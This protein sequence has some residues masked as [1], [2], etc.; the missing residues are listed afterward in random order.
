MMMVSSILPLL[1]HG[2]YFASINLQNAYFHVSIRE[3][4]WRFLSFKILHQT[5]QFTVL[6]F[7]LITAPRVFT[8]TIAVVAAHLRQQGVM[9]FPYLDW[10]IAACSLGNSRTTCN[11]FPSDSDSLGL[12]LNTGEIFFNSVK[13]DKGHRDPLQLYISNG[14][15]PGG[16]VPGPAKRNYF[17]QIPPKSKHPIHPSS[18]RARGLHD[19][20]HSLHK[21]MFQTPPK[22]VHRQLQTIPPS[23]LDLPHDTKI[24]PP[25][26]N[27]VESTLKKSTKAY[28]SILSHHNDQLIELCLGSTHDQSHN[29]GFVVP[30]GEMAPHKL[31]RT[32][33]HIQSPEGLWLT[34]SLTDNMVAM[35]Y[36]NK[37]GSTGSR[38]LTTLFMCLRHWCIDHSVSITAPPPQQ[39]ERPCRQPQQDGGVLPRVEAQP[40]CSPL[41]LR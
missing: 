26:S 22:V 1:Y 20:C 12:Q 17:L 39:T 16:Q 40:N 21:T 28:P 8:K 38:I 29:P 33:S 25:I 14:I 34:S 7:G 36:V 6:L 32:V 30:S 10:L 4:H 18:S 9:V 15:P 11:P 23:Q 24:N 2:D 27:L 37:Q 5:Y 13:K 3:V 41:D 19:P 31:P 35:Y